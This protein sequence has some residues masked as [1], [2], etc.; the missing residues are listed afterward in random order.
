MAT[1]PAVRRSRAVDVDALY[2]Q[3]GPIE[4]CM[5]DPAVTEVMVN[6]PDTICVER[7][8]VIHLTDLRFD[9]EA[10]LMRVIDFIVTSVGR[11]I[12]A[13]DPLCDARL[14]DGSRA[15]AIIPPLALDGPLLTIRK[16]AAEPFTVDDLVRIG[17]LTPEAAAFLQACVL[18]KCNVII[19][20]GTATGKTSL[21]NVLSSFIPQSER[22]V[23]IEDAAELQLNQWHVC[24]LESR[25]P[26]GTGAGRVTIRQL[27][28][29]SL[30]MRPDR[31]VIGECRGEEAIDMLQAMNVGHEGSLTTLHSNSARDALAR[32]ETMVMMSGLELP[33]RA[34]RQQ[35]ASAIHLIVQ[36][37]RLGDG[38]RRVVS[39]TEMMGMEGDT[40]TLQEVFTFESHGQ[41]A[42]GRAI[43]FL[44]PSG[45]RP[46]TLDRLAK[47]GI[48]LPPDL[49]RLYPAQR[50]W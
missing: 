45:V 19:S 35:M 16:F 11:R 1:P 41:D 26:D 40:Q 32:L 21:L 34:I 2:R 39:I 44:K 25:P 50:A 27:L 31:I 14:A 28:I 46:V 42:E 38:A 8:G 13:Q 12:D 5:R 18:G 29:N 9:D 36:L 3:L 4:P 49:A 47:R 6:G 33:I 10:H 20:G 24:R 43:G 48:G 7:D 23:T 30:R 15:N 37:D 22:I 17:T